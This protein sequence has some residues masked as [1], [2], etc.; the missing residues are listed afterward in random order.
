MLKKITLKRCYESLIILGMVFAI[1]AVVG[2]PAIAKAQEIEPVQTFYN[3]LGSHSEIKD[4]G[5]HVMFANF[6]EGLEGNALTLLRSSEITFPA[7][8][9][10][11]GL[12][13]FWVMPFFNIN[14]MPVD[15]YV[16]LFE[17]RGNGSNLLTLWVRKT[18]LGIMLILEVENTN[19]ELSRVYAGVNSFESEKWNQIAFQW[20]CNQ[21]NP[22]RSWGAI[23][24]NKNEVT[25]SWGFCQDVDLTGVTEIAFGE[26]NFTLHDGDIMSLESLSVYSGKVKMNKIVNDDWKKY[27]KLR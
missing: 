1:V 25:K 22:K 9:E 4:A 10:N 13:D 14:T 20:K 3:G 12:V 8:L 16:R 23:S 11:E 18:S 15:S 24:L 6:T 17:A 26:D 2:S 5:G 19:G 7:S 27:K 21:S